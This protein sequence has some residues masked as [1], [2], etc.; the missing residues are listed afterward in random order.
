MVDGTQKGSF[1][2]YVLRGILP[3]AAKARGAGGG[4]GIA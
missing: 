2:I 4:K 3:D 1:E